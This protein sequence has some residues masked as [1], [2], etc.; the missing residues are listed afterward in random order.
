[1]S[2]TN[3]AWGLIKENL[4]LYGTVEGKHHY[5]Q[6]A[7]VT[8][9]KIPIGEFIKNFEGLQDT[10]NTY[11]SDLILTNFGNPETNSYTLSKETSDRDILKALDHLEVDQEWLK[12]N[13]SNDELLDLEESRLEKNTKDSLLT[14]QI[15]NLKN[16]ITLERERFDKPTWGMLN[17]AALGSGAPVGSTAKGSGF[18]GVLYNLVAP[19]MKTA[20]QIFGGWT[21]WGRDEYEDIVENRWFNYNP[22]L[23]MSG[24]TFEEMY[25]SPLQDKL[26]AKR[27][28]RSGLMYLH[29]ADDKA[30]DEYFNR[31]ESIAG[32]RNLIN[33]TGL[34]EA[35]HYMSLENLKEILK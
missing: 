6:N 13:F 29:K 7:K 24:K 4:D 1:M 14:E 34:D 27:R 32:N 3:Q 25:V 9:K 18:A 8:S 10:V 28:E 5:L 17:P 23:R 31:Q 35:L 22:D 2:K 16:A 30:Y 19:V 33:A 12:E 20:T 21:D 26:K 15:D 11:M